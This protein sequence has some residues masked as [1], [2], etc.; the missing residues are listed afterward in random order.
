MAPSLDSFADSLTHALPSFG[1][2]GTAAAAAKVP[3]KPTTLHTFKGAAVESSNLDVVRDFAST[4]TIADTLELDGYSLSPAD[5]VSV[6]RKHRRVAIKQ[7]ANIQLRIDQSVEFLRSQLGNSVYGVTTGFGGSADTRTEDATSLQ[8]ALIEHQLSGVLPTDMSRLSLGRGLENAMPLEVVRGA[9]L[10]RVNSLTR[11]HSAVRPVVLQALVDCLTHGVTPVVPLR[12]SISASGDLSPL[13]YIAAAITGHPDS[14]VHV[15]QDGVERILPAREAL[16]LYG[17]EPV[18]LGPKEGLGL[19]NGTAISAAMATLALHDSHNLALLAQATTALTVEAMVGH[20]GSFAPFIHDVARPHP[21]QVEVARNV[22]TLLDGSSFAVAHE[23][24]VA[25]KD[26]DHELRQDRYPLR[27][28]P[29][30]MGPLVEDLL[31]AY[32][33]LSL[34]NNTTTDNPLIDVEENSVLHGGNFQS[35]HASIS[36][37]K[38]R[39]AMA[40]VGKLAFTQLTEMLNASMNRGLPSC[41]A[42]EDPSL[43]YHTKGLDIA[44]ASYCSELG[45]LANPVTTFVQPAEMGNQAVN[46]LALISARRTAEANDVLSLLLASHVYCAVMAVDLR[47]LEFDFKRQFYPE[48]SSLL[49]QHLGSALGSEA[50]TAELVTKV[51]KA[52]GM[53]LEQNST[54]DLVDRWHDA[55]SFATGVVVQHLASSSL[56]L[57]ALNQWKVASAE[58]AIVVTRQVRE[59]FWATPSSAAPALSY[60]APR[61]RLMYT[62]VRE[63]LGVKARRGDVFLGRQEATIGSNVSRIYE[64]IRDGRIN[65]VLV[66]M[67]A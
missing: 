47:A 15:V 37:E 50:T 66:D 63:E 2:N 43:N 41:L 44:T 11:G 25:V 18:V 53:R 1:S 24:H 33:V 22:R 35:A 38:T 4:S 59:T 32:S 6:A 51:K 13:S 45:Y 8:K 10:I 48:I 57:E 62:F 46:S 17:L 49:T 39:L 9:M 7:D 28:S 34:E 14:K 40:L 16:A 58:R 67:L 61:T 64:A 54:Y 3:H 27:T 20:Q 21:G 23:E 55:F 60:L 12:G 31:H 30:F 29:Q 26:D 5:V 42:A 19:V 36:M 56:S 65:K 52:L